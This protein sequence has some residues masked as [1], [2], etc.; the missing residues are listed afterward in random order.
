MSLVQRDD[1]LCCQN[2]GVVGRI[3]GG[4]A[5]FLTEDDPFYEGKY[6]SHVKFVPRGDGFFA[7]L[8]L[9]VVMQGYPTVVAKEIRAGSIVVEIGCAGGIEWFGERFRMIGLDLSRSALML[10]G[11]S[12]ETVVQCNATHMPL[13]DASVDGIVSSCLFE[14]LTRQQKTALLSEACRVLRP[15]GK[16]VFFYDIETD[17][18]VIS[19]YRR[20]RPDLYQA[21]FLDGDGHIGYESISANGQYFCAAGL[22]ITREVFHERTPF[23]S[24]STWYKLSQWPGALGVLARVGRVATSG[25]IRLPALAVLM[26]IDATIGRLFPSRFARCV[27]TIAQKP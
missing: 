25:P 27:T 12:Y 17:N 4:V 19:I 2:C 26:A 22:K 9:R 20:R 11:Q 24:T 5:S 15:G 8:P 10:A 14:H 7:T 1:K 23:L 18:P 16:L 21:L 6:N 3:V 13:A